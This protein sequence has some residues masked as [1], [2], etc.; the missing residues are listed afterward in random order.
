MKVSTPACPVIDPKE[1]GLPAC[2]RNIKITIEYDGSNYCGWEKQNNGIGIQKLIEDAVFKI[3]GERTTINGSGRTDAGVHA[4]G[5]VA[6]FTLQHQ[7]PIRD[8]GRA[9]DAVL[10]P[11]VAVLAAEDVSLFFHARFS[12]TSKLY[13]YSVL[14]GRAKAPLLRHRTHHIRHP[15]DLAAMQEVAALFVGTHDFSAFCKEAERIGDCVRTI[16]KC[17]II[18]DGRLIH[19][20]LAANGFLY[21]MVRIIVGTLVY[22]GSGKL[23]KEEIASLLNGGERK[24]SGPTVPA[25]GL[26]LVEVF[27]E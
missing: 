9:L 20:E 1:L 10:P 19:F 16:H 3:T 4:L 22:V 14:T 27:Y 6:S 15:L 17:R 8:L 2:P 25:S 26:H 11:D 18:E 12:A 23:G 24:F 5:Q 21:N 13:R 7:I